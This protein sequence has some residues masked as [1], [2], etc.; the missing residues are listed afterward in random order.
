MRWNSSNGH[1]GRLPSK[2]L[3]LRMRYMSTF[4]IGYTVSF[5]DKLN[6]KT[7][8]QTGKIVG[9]DPTPPERT[10]RKGPCYVIRVDGID[11]WL[12]RNE[13]EILE[14]EDVI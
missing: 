4:E 5:L 6:L 13:D 9:I 8:A 2:F 7:P 12:Y 10:K 3:I 11:E 14:V 1:D